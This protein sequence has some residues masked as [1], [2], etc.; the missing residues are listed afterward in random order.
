MV[1]IRHYRKKPVVIRAVQFEYSDK[2]IAL[3]DEFLIDKSDK[4]VWFVTS[5][6]RHPEAIGKITVR[7]LE[8][9]V[10]GQEGDYIIQGIEGEFYICNKKIFERTYEDVEELC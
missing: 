7:S 2:G 10:T 8:G 4:K 6:E 9:D 1:E 5:K 3:L